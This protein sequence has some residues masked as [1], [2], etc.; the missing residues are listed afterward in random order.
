MLSSV[1][2]VGAAFMLWLL[3][4][5]VSFAGL[6]VWLEL[7]CMIPRSGGEKV[8]LEAAYKRPRLLATTVFA[9][10]VILLG[11]TAAG[12]IVFSEYVII[13]AGYTASDWEKRGIA[14]AVVSA[15]CSVHAF[16]PHFGVKGMNAFV[17]VKIATIVFIIVAGWAVLGHG[18][19]RIPDPRASF[20]NAFH[21]TSSS[22]YEWAIA[23]F[24]VLDSYAGWSNAAYVVNEIR[25]PVRTLKIAGPLGLGACGVFYMLAN[26]S[27][28][29]AATPEEI[30]KSGQTVASL[31]MYNVFGTAGEKAISVLIALSAFGNVMT[32]T[33]AQARV[34]QELAKEGVIPW[35]KFWASNW[36]FGSPAAGLL[37]HW[38]PSFII[39]V[40]IPFGDAYNFILD[41]EG[42]P[43][44]VVD[45]FVVLGFFWLRYSAPQLSRPFR[46]WWPVAVF[47][48]AAQGFLMVAPFLSPPGGKGDTSLPYWLSS[49]VGI[50]ILVGGAVWWAVRFKIL[51]WVMRV[52]LKPTHETLG[53]GTAVV[54]YKGVKRL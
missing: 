30:R 3:G 6:C 24:K 39:I 50:A 49:V 40:A 27:Y 11:F 42:Y 33:F 8:F 54:V 47:Y 1:G 43:G 28:F 48:L 2:S 4:L 51:P 22:G 15:I 52:D 17:V 37:L 44:S 53:D 5:L 7:S 25:N 38:I 41:V 20:R 18:S 32:V 34:N 45:F 12:C 46:C 16:S 19:P 26:V 36:P 35:P 31:F 9:F 10:Q 21:G 14:I 23:L 13:A 29:A